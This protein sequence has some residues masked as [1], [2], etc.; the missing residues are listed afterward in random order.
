LG[1]ALV[2]I[3]TGYCKLLNTHKFAEAISGFLVPWEPTLKVVKPFAFGL[4]ALE[5]LVGS[6]VVFA[7]LALAVSSVLNPFKSLAL[8]T[9]CWASRCLSALL[10]VFIIA[11]AQAWLREIRLADCGCGGGDCAV[12]L[13]Y[14]DSW[15]GDLYAL[16]TGSPPNP[17]EPAIVPLIR[18]FF[19]LFGSCLFIFKPNLT[20]RST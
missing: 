8:A 12:L 6:V 16:I 9:I 2:F 3:E 15:V 1:I 10:V 19:L 4:A 14:I 11:L 7:L 5:L 20:S 17:Y 18:D 13:P